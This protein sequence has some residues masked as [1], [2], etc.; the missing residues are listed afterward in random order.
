VSRLPTVAVA[1]RPP[2]ELP[3][4]LGLAVADWVAEV[5]SSEA[6]TRRR[7]WMTPEALEFDD[8]TGAW[9]DPP[10]YDEW[11]DAGGG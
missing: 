11:L 2:A 6:R 9:S 7:E 3:A 5:S 10:R 4:G 1:P 8:R